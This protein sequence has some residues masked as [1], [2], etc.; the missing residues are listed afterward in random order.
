MYTHAHIRVQT[1]MQI[2]A[3]HVIFNVPYLPTGGTQILREYCH[4][5]NA[6]LGC[7]P[8]LS[9]NEEIANSL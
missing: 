2:H 7:R 8:T 4:L 5:S 9:L 6:C 3:T 1:Y